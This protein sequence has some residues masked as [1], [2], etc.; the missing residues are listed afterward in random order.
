MRINVQEIIKTIQLLSKLAF[1]DELTGCLNRNGLKEEIR[2]KAIF[3][4][5][6]RKLKEKRKVQYAFLLIDID[7]FKKVND[8]FGYKK[9]DYVLKL[10]AL[11][12]KKFFRKKDIICRYGGDE[13]LI[14]IENINKSQLKRRLEQVKEKIL[15]DISKTGAGLSIAGVLFSSNYSFNKV[16]KKANELLKKSKTSG[17]GKILIENL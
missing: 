3:L 2:K 11:N 4:N 6:N 5:K 7:N 17:K 10:V 14:I 13:F 12:F 15:K 1:Y 9:G 8:Q 16:F